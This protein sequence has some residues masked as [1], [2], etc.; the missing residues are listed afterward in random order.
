MDAL[1]LFDHFSRW[2]LERPPRLAVVNHAAES[3]VTGLSSTSGL[4][5]SPLELFGLFI[6]LCQ[7]RHNWYVAHSHGYVTTI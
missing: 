7:R 1:R 3:E 6:R 4:D 5:I 2:T